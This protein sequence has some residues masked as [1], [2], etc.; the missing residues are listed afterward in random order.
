MTNVKAQIPNECQMLKPKT[1]NHEPTKYGKPERRKR[2][3][4]ELPIDIGYFVF[5]IR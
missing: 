5:D 2:V 1:N 4:S 3:N